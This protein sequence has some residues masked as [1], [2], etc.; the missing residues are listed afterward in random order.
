MQDVKT[1]HAFVPSDDIGRGVSFEMADVKSLA[2]RIREHIEHVKLGFRGIESW[3]VGAWRMKCLPRQP[4]LLPFWLEFRKG[5][6]F[7]SLAHWYYLVQ[8]HKLVAYPEARIA[9][10]YPHRRR[11]L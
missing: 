9:N 8:I 4:K 7:S 2:A 1:F 10:G 6:L 5:K 11:Q 3:F